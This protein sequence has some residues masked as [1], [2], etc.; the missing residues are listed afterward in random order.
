MMAKL[1]FSITRKL[2]AKR[3][4]AF[5]SAASLP[6]IPTGPLM[7]LALTPVSLECAKAPTNSPIWTNTPETCSQGVGPGR[8]NW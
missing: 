5:T 1:T 7:S 4:S 3:M 8:C 2:K 6:K